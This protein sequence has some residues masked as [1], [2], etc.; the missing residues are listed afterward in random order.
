M[1]REEPRPATSLTVVNGRD[2]PAT[3]VTVRTEAK[4]VEHARPLPSQAKAVLKLPKLKGC[5]VAV[6]ATFE[7]GDVS[8]VGDIDLCKIKLVRLTD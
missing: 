4:T 6:S 3:N 8:E 1:K 7:G 5:V 2:V